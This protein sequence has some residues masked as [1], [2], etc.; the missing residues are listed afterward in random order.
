MAANKVTKNAWP[1]CSHKTKTR[2]P[3]SVKMLRRLLARAS[4]NS[5]RSD[6]APARVAMLAFSTDPAYGFV[7]MRNT[8]PRL[9]AA[10]LFNKFGCPGSLS[11]KDISCGE[12]HHPEAGIRNMLFYLLPDGREKALHD[13]IQKSGFL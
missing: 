11:Q 1:M 3:S 10:P 5:L 7:F 4:A 2:M 12:D 13:C 6:R 9:S 8:L